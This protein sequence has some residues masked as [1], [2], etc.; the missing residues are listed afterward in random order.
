MDK[1]DILLIQCRQ[2]LGQAKEGMDLN[3]IDMKEMLE[4]CL[5][6]LVVQVFLQA[7]RV[8]KGLQ[9]VALHLLYILAL[10]CMTIRGLRTVS[11]TKK[12]FSVTTLASVTPN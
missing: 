9:E 7:S 3:L 4:L 12:R 1:E 11:K 6:K 2:P 8:E 10:P 5:I